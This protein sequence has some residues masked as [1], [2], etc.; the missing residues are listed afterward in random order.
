MSARKRKKKRGKPSDTRG[1]FTLSAVVAL[2][3]VMGVAFAVYKPFLGHGGS[4]QGI[5]VVDVEATKKAILNKEGSDGGELGQ[6]LGEVLLGGI[7]QKLEVSIDASTVEMKFDLGGLSKSDK[8]TYT[9]TQLGNGRYQLTTAGKGEKEAKT[10][11]ATV[12]G[13]RMTWADNGDDKELHLVRK[14]GSSRPR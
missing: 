1:A 12:R 7:L 13:D 4:L 2:A 11:I 5:W 14:G 9:S 10:V 8:R 6:A 3:V